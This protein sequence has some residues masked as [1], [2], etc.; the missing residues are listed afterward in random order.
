MNVMRGLKDIKFIRKDNQWY[1]F[2]CLSKKAGLYG[3]FKY[4][5]NL[6][7]V[8][9]GDCS[10]NVGKD[11]ENL[12]FHQ[13]KARQMMAFGPHNIERFRKQ[14]NDRRLQG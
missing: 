9:G 7:E 1:Y 14:I 5:G 8:T 10:N 11:D 2:E 4:Q 12:Y 6:Y 3:W 13:F